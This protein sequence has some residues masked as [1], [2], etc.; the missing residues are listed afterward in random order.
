LTALFLLTPHRVSGQSANKPDSNPSGTEQMLRNIFS[1]VHL[2]RV[3]FLRAS[4]NTYRSQ[5]VLNRIKVEQDQVARL[6]REVNDIQDK[7]AETKAVQAKKKGRLEELVKKKDAGMVS[8]EEVD[9]TALEEP[10]I[11]YR[12]GFTTARQ[13]AE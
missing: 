4:A 7:V 5:V 9:A 10:L 8:P 2:L 13:R 12:G 11:F 3:E 1:E 6:T